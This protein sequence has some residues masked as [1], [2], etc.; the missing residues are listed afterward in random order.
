MKTKETKTKTGDK[1]TPKKQKSL[2]GGIAVV[3]PGDA[4]AFVYENADSLLKD[5][6]KGE[7]FVDKNTRYFELGKEVKVSIVIEAKV[8]V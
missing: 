1:V 5:I 4:E 3:F 7:L 8:A 2:S 6:T